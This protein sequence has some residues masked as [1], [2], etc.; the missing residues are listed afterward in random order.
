MSMLTSMVVLRLWS[1]TTILLA[2]GGHGSA[3]HGSGGIGSGGLGSGGLGTV[4]SEIPPKTVSEAA[5]FA[6]AYS[7]AWE[8]KISSRSW[9]VHADQVSKTAPSGEYLTLGSFMIR[10]K[11]NYLPMPQ[12]QL[13]FGFLFKLDDESIQRHVN[14]RTVKTINEHL[15]RNEHLKNESACEES[16]LVDTLPDEAEIE[17]SSSDDE[18]ARQN[19]PAAFPD[20]KIRT[21]SLNSEGASSV[22]G[23][24]EDDDE[25]I[26]VNP[27]EPKVK[28]QSQ[29][30]E[31]IKQKMAEKLAQEREAAIE[32]AKEKAATD[33]G[34]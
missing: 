16:S 23:F 3:G 1:R 17:V 2:S 11:K 26:I 30:R 12:L 18:D 8:A 10:G 20:T 32:E 14:E 13:A 6:V 29:K 31:L 7:S 27:S 4:G 24:H 15:V 19:S 22:D 25:M 5:V 33:G 9:W 28:Q 34:E 21:I